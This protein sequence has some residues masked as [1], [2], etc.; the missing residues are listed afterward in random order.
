MAL[1][2][3]AWQELLAQCVGGDGCHPSGM[4]AFSSTW[5]A[6]PSW[7][8]LEWGVRHGQVQASPCSNC[9]CSLSHGLWL[10]FTPSPYGMPLRGLTILPS[11]IAMGSNSI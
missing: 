3:Q 7:Y 8:L 1:G 9:Q 5:V 4:Y 10:S 2:A 6:R 11:S